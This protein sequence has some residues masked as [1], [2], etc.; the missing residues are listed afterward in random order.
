MAFLKSE[1]RVITVYSSF[2]F[3][4]A[5]HLYLYT[6]IRF[7]WFFSSAGWRISVFSLY[8]C[9]R[10]SK[11]LSNLDLHLWGSH[12]ILLLQARLVLEFFKYCMKGLWE[13][14]SPLSG[15]YS[16]GVLLQKAEIIFRLPVL[17]SRPF[18]L[19]FFCR[20]YRFWKYWKANIV[21]FLLIVWNFACFLI[22]IT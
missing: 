3:F 11:P 9:S 10:Y 6:V 18:L 22:M 13:C 12:K 17:A 2:F 4:I 21:S 7:P 5:L 14:M 8:S 19:Q 1:A 16:A 20:P 15:I